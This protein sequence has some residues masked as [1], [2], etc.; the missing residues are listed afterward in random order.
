[1]TNENNAAVLESVSSLTGA[2]KYTCSIRSFNIPI[3]L[4][5]MNKYESTP[6][7]L[8]STVILLF[9]ISSACSATL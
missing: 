5:L 1:M 4:S 9:F 7:A 2:P 3:V 6:L 8:I